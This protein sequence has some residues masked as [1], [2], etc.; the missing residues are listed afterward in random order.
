[1]GTIKGVIMDFDLKNKCIIRQ[2]KL[3]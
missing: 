3:H 2:A 1:M